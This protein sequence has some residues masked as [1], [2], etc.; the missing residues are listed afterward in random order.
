MSNIRDIA[1]LAGVSI[2]TVSRIFSQDETLHVTDDTRS[3]VME[4]AKKLN[5]HYKPKKPQLSI[6]CIM[7][8]TYNYSDPYFYEILNGIQEYCSKNNA[9]ISLI[10]SYSQF[11]E[12]KS[13]LEEKIK[14]L[15]GLIAT[16]VP[17]G[18]LDQL[19]RLN[20]KIVFIDNYHYG[21]CNVGFNKVY[22]NRVI[23]N[24]LID[25]GYKKIAYI[26]GPGQHPNIHDSHRLMVYRE[27]LRKNNIPYD[28]SLIYDCGWRKEICEQQ[29]EILLKDHPDIQVIFAGSD[30]LA[31]T[32]LNKLQKMGKRCPEDIGIVGFNDN[33]IAK[34]MR[35]A[36]TTLHL[37][38][39]EMGFLAARML[40]EQISQ[41][42]S[43][44]LEV[45]LPCE[46]IV[47]S[48]TRQI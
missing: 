44:N 25:C 27:E 24:Y 31:S 30:S 14:Q 39:K 23:M 9:V 21:Y 20:H 45:S 10:I 33:E 1:K 12:M 17:G 19:T 3:R 2:T 40:I 48:S 15:D 13:G 22:A 37:P 18:N 38:S 11:L 4:A 35:P 43:L 47:R 7:S 41:N 16:D 8:L 32:I 28:P 29:I 34:T 42:I 26:G 5:Y 36:L 46:L 6:G